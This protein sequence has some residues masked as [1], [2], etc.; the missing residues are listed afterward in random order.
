MLWNGR[1][2]GEYL[3]EIVL[4]MHAFILNVMYFESESLHESLHSLDILTV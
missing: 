4:Y 3:V 1:T 2:T